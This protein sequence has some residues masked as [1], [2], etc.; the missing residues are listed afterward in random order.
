MSR[1]R[2]A[3]GG[4]EDP[5]PRNVEFGA[6]AMDG[7]QRPKSPKYFAGLQSFC[8]CVLWLFFLLYTLDTMGAQLLRTSRLPAVRVCHII[9]N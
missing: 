4:L 1:C 3:V 9:D 8:P 5:R 2:V 6:L 7:G